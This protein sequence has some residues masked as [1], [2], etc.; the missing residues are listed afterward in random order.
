MLDVQCSHLIPFVEITIL[1][2][3]NGPLYAHPVAFSSLAAV[4]GKKTFDR[5]ARRT[6]AT[7][8]TPTLAKEIVMSISSASS[9]C[10]SCGGTNIEQGHLHTTGKVHFRPSH[11]KFLTLHTADVEVRVDVCTDCGHVNMIADTK[12]LATILNHAHQHPAA[13]SV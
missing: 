3:P 6:H 8:V 11:S 5:I 10:A 1:I 13:A 12:K 9:K 2:T 4:A 7:C